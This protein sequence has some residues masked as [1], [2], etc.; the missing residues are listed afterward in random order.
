MNQKKNDSECATVRDTISEFAGMPCCP[1]GSGSTGPRGSDMDKMMEA[2]PCGDLLKR[3]RLA[4][5]TTLVAL[6][7][8][9]LILQAGWVLGVI[10]FFR[11]F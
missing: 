9:V 11:T 3:H 4:A 6:G 8:G 5:F 1:G 7:F 2:C 10:A